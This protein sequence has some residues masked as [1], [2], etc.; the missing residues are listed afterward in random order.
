MRRLRLRRRRNGERPNRWP[1]WSALTRVGIGLLTWA[2]LCLTLLGYNLFPGRLSLWIGEPSPALVRAPR[3]ARYIDKN[4]T[5]RVR[6]EAAQRVFPVYT[7]LRSARPDAERRVAQDFT[8][9]REAKAS[10]ESPR[11]LSPALSWLPPGSRAWLLSAEPA[12]LSRVEDEAVDI[13][14]EMMSRQIREATADLRVAREDAD[15][16]ARQR[17]RDPGAGALLAAVVVRNIARTYN[18]DEEA[19]K[20]AR[21]AAE[22]RVQEVVR[23]IDA[24]QAI[25]FAGERVTRQ[26]LDMLQALGLTSPKLDLRRLLSAALIVGLIV[27][28]LGLQTRHWARRVYERPKWLLLLSLLAVASMFLISLL[29]LALPNVWM[30]IVPAASVMAATLLGDTIGI[31]LALGL[32]LLVGLMADTGL[33]GTLLSLGSAAAALAFAAHFWPMSRLR[34]VVGATA[35]ANLVLVAAVGLWQGQQAGALAREAALAAVLY[36]PGAA[37]LALGGIYML[38]RPFGITTHLTLLELSNP[39]LPLLKQL[40]TE[41]PGT[42]HHSIM[43]AS[44]AEAAAEAIGADALLTRVGALYHDIGKLVRPG[45]F[46]ENQ[47]LLGVDNVHDRLSSSLSGLI[48]ISHVKDGVELARQHGLPPEVVSIIA[49]HHGETTM[50]YF[51]HQA[52]ASARPEEVSE[53][54]FR[55][56]GPLP[57]TR[58]AAIVM[59]ADGVHAAS[60]ALSEPTPQRVQQITREIFRE[61]VVARQLEQCD[62]TFRQIAAAEAVMGRVLA[63]ALC[64]DRIAYPEPASLGP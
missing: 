12:Q 43:V 9:L 28:L 38:Q 26:H 63:V 18:L 8:V 64:R 36:A 61:R 52:L 42:Y 60:K 1:H 15:L 33:P 35:A 21:D 29:T 56:P 62:L 48:I 20:A 47:G 23:T 32:S 14:R 37:L 41:A 5:E 50:T 58:E 16:I 46:V 10:A 30:L 55:Y 22:R 45:F 2:A 54:Q 40:Q 31:A 3:M 53:Q 59:L 39:Q 24:G 6:K 34:V 11:D 4:E 44:L 25:I 27:L 51:Y 13:V 49:E 57:S 7:E 17:E 19:T